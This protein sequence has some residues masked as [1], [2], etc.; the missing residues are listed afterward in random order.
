MFQCHK[1]PLKL[2]PDPCNFLSRELLSQGTISKLNTV[3]WLAQNILAKLQFS[4]AITYLV[5][6][7]RKPQN[8]TFARGADMTIHN[9][10]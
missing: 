2:D 9:H 8:H 7:M 3:V 5:N 1:S 4:H 6:T 10:A